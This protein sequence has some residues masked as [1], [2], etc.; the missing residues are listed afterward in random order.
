MESVRRVFLTM[1]ASMSRPTTDANPIV[2]H[3][4]KLIQLAGKVTKYMVKPANLGAQL[5]ISAEPQVDDTSMWPLSAKDKF[6][7]MSVVGD[8]NA[9]LSMSYRKHLRIGKAC[10]EVDGDRNDIMTERSKMRDETRVGALI[11]QKLHAFAGTASAGTSRC[12]RWCVASTAS[13]AYARAA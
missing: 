10:W 7:E 8:E 5:G 3:D 1:V 2:G 13:C 4:E 11:Q 6:T 12:S 9:L